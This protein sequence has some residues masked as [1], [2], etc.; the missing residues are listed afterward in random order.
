MT[1]MF[2]LFVLIFTSLGDSLA[3]S[4]ERYLHVADQADPLSSGQLLFC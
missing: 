4:G 2:V 1:G 3:A